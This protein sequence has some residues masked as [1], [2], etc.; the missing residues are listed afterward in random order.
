MS[1]D[2]RTGK[3][4]RLEMNNKIDLI[5]GCQEKMMKDLSDIKRAMY[6]PDEG[7]Y[8]RIK[9]IELWKA[10]LID[11]VEEKIEHQTVTNGEIRVSQIE[12]S[13]ATHRKIQWMVIGSAVST[14]TALIIKA[15]IL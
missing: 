15:F 2:S 14:I 3:Y 12:T 7:I 13:L 10:D 4:A 1:D 6:E 8:S 11:R 9:D 5:L